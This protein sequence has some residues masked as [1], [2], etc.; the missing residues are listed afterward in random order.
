MKRQLYDPLLTQLNEELNS[1]LLYLYMSKIAKQK[2]WHGA[3][4]W[5]TIQAKEE[6]LHFKKFKTYL[7]R[8]G[9]SV[10]TEPTDNHD[11]WNNMDDMFKDVLKHEKH[12]SSGI[13]SL[14]DLSE[15][16]GDEDT[17]KFLKWFLIEQVKEENRA[18]EVLSK[19]RRSE[20]AGD[21]FM[22]ERSTTE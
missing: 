12:I 6:F 8:S 14:W 11:Y 2:G 4:N 20:A 16:H 19:V 17:K 13:R 7:E 5:L 15:R 9:Y 10:V 22:A 3:A 1:G 18:I 21:S